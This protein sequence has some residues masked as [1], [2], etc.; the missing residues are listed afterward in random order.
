MSNK[1]DLLT[2]R[3]KLVEIIGEKIQY[4][5]LIPTYIFNITMN[6]LNNGC[7]SRADYENMVIF[8]MN[9][10]YY[11]NLLLE[12]EENAIWKNTSWIKRNINQK[13]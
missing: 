13:R 7:K 10:I 5:E 4:K 1:I 2:A 12:D 11:R 3:Y 6:Y 8:Y 9:N